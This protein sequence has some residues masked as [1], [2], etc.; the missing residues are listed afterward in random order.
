MKLKKAEAAFLPAAKGLAHL[1]N[2]ENTSL[3]PVDR[4]P[5]FAK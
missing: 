4:N 3:H 5:E 2:T 1:G